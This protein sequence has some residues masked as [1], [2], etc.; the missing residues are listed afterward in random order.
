MIPES[1]QTCR[2][3]RRFIKPHDGLIWPQA[4]VG[5]TL[6]PTLDAGKHLS[7]SG[8]PQP[9]TVGWVVTQRQKG[10]QPNLGAMLKSQ[11]GVL[12]EGQAGSSPILR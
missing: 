7:A 6:A 3:N 1:I 12:G 9:A 10:F 5:F 8:P 11:R 4:T 2:R